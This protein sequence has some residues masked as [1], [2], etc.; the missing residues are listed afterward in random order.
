MTKMIG[1]SAEKGFTLIEVMAGMGLFAFALLGLLALM[2]QSLEFGHFSSNRTI[3]I[4]EIRQTIEDIRRV[5]D[6]SGL[7]TVRSTN[8]DETL[9][10]S[11]LKSGSI[12]VTDTSGN[13]LSSNSSDPLPVRI[14]ITWSEK[15]KTTSYTVDT[16]VTKR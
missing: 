15:G 5:A 9:S 6:V 14:K 8:F 13:A 7:T 3:A 2:A 11:T 10:D 16:K 1:K 12:T 4:N